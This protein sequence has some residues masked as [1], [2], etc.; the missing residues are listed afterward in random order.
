VNDNQDTEI[1]CCFCLIYGDC[2]KQ[3]MALTAEEPS[4]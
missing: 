2:F 3:S 4:A 1:P